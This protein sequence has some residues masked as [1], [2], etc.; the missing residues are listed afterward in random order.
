MRGPGKGDTMIES[1]GMVGQEL[2]EL[3]SALI[4]PDKI[5][6][7]PLYDTVC[8]HF[9]TFPLDNKLPDNRYAALASA[10]HTINDK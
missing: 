3:E 5:S 10:Y 4:A 6:H 7:H 9:H 2:W 1:N 8:T